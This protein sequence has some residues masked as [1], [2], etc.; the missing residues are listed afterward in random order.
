[1]NGLEIIDEKDPS[2]ADKLLR[3]EP[4][5]NAYIEINNVIASAPIEQVTKDDI[6]RILADHKISSE[7]ARSRLTYITPVC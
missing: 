1:M 4:R 6:D 5:E 2:L 7:Q 3:R